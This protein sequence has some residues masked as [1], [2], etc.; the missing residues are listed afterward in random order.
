MPSFRGEENILILDYGDCCITVN[1]LQN[2]ELNNLNGCIAWYVNFNLI[3]LFLKNS[4]YSYY[5]ENILL[6]DIIDYIY[7][8][9]SYFKNWYQNE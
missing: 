6:P 3:K 2:T 4:I 8:Y 1:I 9:G 7:E 5:L